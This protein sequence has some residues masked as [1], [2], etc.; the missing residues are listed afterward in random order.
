MID[1]SIEGSGEATLDL[2][3]EAVSMWQNNSQAVRIILEF[4]IQPLVENVMA[5]LTLTEAG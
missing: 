1:M 3:D 5:R 2:G 4:A